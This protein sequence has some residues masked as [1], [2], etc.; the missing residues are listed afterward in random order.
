M[1]YLFLLE[2]LESNHISAPYITIIY[3][4]FHAIV[5]VQKKYYKLQ[6]TILIMQRLT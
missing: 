3:T 5:N 1:V 4:N 2:K 6:K